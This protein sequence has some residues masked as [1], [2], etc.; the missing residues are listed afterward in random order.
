MSKVDGQG[1]PIDPTS[2]VRV[3]IFCWRLLL[4]DFEALLLKLE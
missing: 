4:E 1:G 3:T 2:S